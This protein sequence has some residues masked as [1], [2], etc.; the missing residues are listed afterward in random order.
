MTTALATRTNTRRLASFTARVALL[1]DVRHDVEANHDNNR[2]WPTSVTDPRMRMLAAGWSTRIS[3]NMI[4]TYRAVISRADSYG[5]D[6]LI[7]LPDAVLADMVRP[8][9]LPGTRIRYLQSLAAFVDRTDLVLDL[10]TADLDVLIERF[11]GEV[12][13]ASYKVA[14]CAVLYARGYHC[15]V[16]PVDS[17]MITRLAPVLGLEVGSGPIAHEQMRHTLQTAV[18]DNPDYYRRLAGD[19][20]YQVTIPADAAP[21]WWLHLVLIYFKR[22]YL[23]RIH[24]QLCENRPVCSRVLDCTHRSG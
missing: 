21:T 15:G 24:P 16:I 2:W 6:Q 8:L 14:Q 11:A 18:N 23:N 3:Y 1:N 17:G 22:H 12:D 4:G 13:Q 5:F 10:A 19:L 20:G 7:Q 9:G